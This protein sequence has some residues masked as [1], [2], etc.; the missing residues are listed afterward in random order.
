MISRHGTLL[1]RTVNWHYSLH[2]V[3]PIVTAEVPLW[4]CRSLWVR[5]ALA[6]YATCLLF[7]WK[8][9][10]SVTWLSILPLSKPHAHYFSVVSASLNWQHHNNWVGSVFRAKIVLVRAALNKA[11]LPLKNS[12]VTIILWS[13]GKLQGAVLCGL[14]L[15]IL[16]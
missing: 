12:I 2:T 14:H 8:L 11:K 1:W 10:N 3:S 6:W 13:T 7:C 15:L 9:V 5:S 16:C 4:S